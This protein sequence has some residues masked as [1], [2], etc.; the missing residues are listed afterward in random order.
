[1]NKSDMIET[2]REMKK[3]I[4]SL[5]QDIERFE[6]ALK[7]SNPE[8]KFSQLNNFT[9]M[10]E[11]KKYKNINE[12][13]DEWNAKDFLSYYFNLY[14][15]LYSKSDVRENQTNFT[16]EINIIK[17]V[18]AN[19][20][21]KNDKVEFKKYLKFVYENEDKFSWL[22]SLNFHTVFSLR[23]DALYQIYF[24][25]KNINLNKIAQNEEYWK[26]YK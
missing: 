12:I 21:F 4:L 1:M 25:S 23:T 5:T 10:A 24:K 8:K 16:K 6:K 20:F 2:I 18:L 19:D 11:V 9:E 3:N 22:T 13:S 17:K 14:K 15:D 26:E 7:S